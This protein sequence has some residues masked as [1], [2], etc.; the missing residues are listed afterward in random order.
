MSRPTFSSEGPLCRIVVRGVPHPRGG[1]YCPDD[2]GLVHRLLEWLIAEKIFTI[3]TSWGGGSAYFFCYLD[4][5][6]K[7]LAFLREHADE[8]DP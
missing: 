4:D 6:P 2:Q 5:E 1:P 7:V 8:V 3:T